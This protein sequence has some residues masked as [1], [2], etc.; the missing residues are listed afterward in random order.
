MNNSWIENFLALPVELKQIILLKLFDNFEWQRYM[1]KYRGYYDE[2]NTRCELIH[3]DKYKIFNADEKSLCAMLN[4][5]FYSFWKMG[6]IPNIE[7]LSWDSC[8]IQLLW[9]KAIDDNEIIIFKS[10]YLSSIQRPLEY[11]II[12]RIAFHGN[13]EMIKFIYAH[14]GLEENDDWWSYIQAL[15]LA[16]INGHLEVTQYL[17]SKILLPLQNFNLK[18]NLFLEFI[19]N[20]AENGHIHIVKWLISEFEE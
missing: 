2:W 3:S 15:S 1:S 11:K 17:S 19:L 16:V 9:E 10:L 8:F 14:E 13:L 7:E 12:E 4:N 6:I 20:A 18:N 5:G